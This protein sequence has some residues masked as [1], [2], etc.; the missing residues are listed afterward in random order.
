MADLIF[1]TDLQ[2]AAR[3]AYYHLRNAENDPRALLIASWLCAAL[4]KEGALT[5]QEARPIDPASKE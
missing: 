4:V 3:Q 1:E 5:S 2:S